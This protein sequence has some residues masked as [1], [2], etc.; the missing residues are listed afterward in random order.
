MNAP[1]TYII[2]VCAMGDDTVM[3]EDVLILLVISSKIFSECTDFSF[4]ITYQSYINNI[5]QY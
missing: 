2:R 4:H 1:I 5:L 3:Y